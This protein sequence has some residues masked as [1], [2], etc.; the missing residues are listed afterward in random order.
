[1]LAQLI[2]IETINTVSMIACVHSHSAFR[3]CFK[4]SAVLA[5]CQTLWKNGTTVT[6]RQMD[7]MVEG[8]GLMDEY[9]SDRFDRSLIVDKGQMSVTSS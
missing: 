9:E 5:D 1:M 6:W 2:D 8:D 4:L 7:H 3:S